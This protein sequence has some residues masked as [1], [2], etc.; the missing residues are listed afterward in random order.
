MEIE[1]FED[2]DVLGRALEEIL[3]GDDFLSLVDR[4]VQRTGIDADPDGGMMLL[5]FVDDRLDAVERADVPWVDAD[6]L[7][8]GFQASQSQ[9]VIEMDVGHQGD[10]HPLLDFLEGEG[11]FHIEAGKAHQIGPKGGGAVDLLAHLLDFARL[12][13]AH[14]LDQDLFLSAKPKLA[15]V[16][17]SGLAA[18]L[19]IEDILEHRS[20]NL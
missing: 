12:D 1:V 7:H 6:R 2:L 10:L 13:G 19:H 16:D 14:R 8:P 4:F 15:K 17:G 5:G 11:V 3:G 18:F 9:P 20:P